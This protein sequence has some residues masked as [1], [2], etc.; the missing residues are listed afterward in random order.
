MKVAHTESSINLGGQELRILD[1]IR[2]AQ[3]HGHEFQLLA[4]EDSAIYREAAKQGLPRHPIPFRGSLNPKAVLALLHFVLRNKIDVIDCHSSRDA[5]T[6]MP[7]RLFGVPVVR[8]QHIGNRLRDDLAHR[9]TWRCGATRVIAVSKSI[10]DQI[11][12]Q[13]L[14][15]REKISVVGEGI[16]FERFNP[17]VDGRAAR[18][19]FNVPLSA[20]VASVIGMIRPDKGQRHLV[21]AVDAIVERVP[22]AYFFIV[23]SPTRPE[24]LIDLKEEIKRVK[25]KDRIVLAGFRNDVER[26]IAAS[27]A[28]V[29][30]SEIEGMPQVIPQ[31]FAMKRPVIASNVGGVPE[32]VRH[33]ETGFLY[34]FGDVGNLT[35]NVVS[36][37]ENVP[38]AQVENAHELTVAELSFDRMMAGTLRVY[39]EAISKR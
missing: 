14:K 24:F 28:I 8:S 6:A 26:F 17:G 13:G 23:G 9:L 33:G 22:D 18:S 4:R 21:R 30:T 20:R 2:W 32:L 15:P 39:E 16:D 3:N 25:H 5:S 19:S 31:A 11:V 38:R 29:L 7:A 1:H 10:A 37:F 36:V 35:E 12:S 27:D 34:P